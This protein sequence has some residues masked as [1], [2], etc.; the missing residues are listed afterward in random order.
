MV[1]LWVKH[2][3]IKMLIDSGATGLFI[4]PKL[5]G[6]AS[7][8]TVEKLVPDKIKLADGHMIHNRHV[9]RVTYRASHS[10]DTFHIVE[11]GDFDMVLG[12]SWLRRINPS[13]D[14]IQYTITFKFNDKPE[15]YVQGGPKICWRL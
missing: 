11:L 7:L 4:D 8:T 13:I 12:K 5:V 14:W 6:S 2:R 9:A 1:E 15:G 3:P 10:H